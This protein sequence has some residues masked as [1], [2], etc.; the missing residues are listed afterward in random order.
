MYCHLRTDGSP[1]YAEVPWRPESGYRQSWMPVNRR[2][3]GPYE[4]VEMTLRLLTGMGAFATEGCI[5][6]S[7]AGCGSVVEDA[8]YF[9]PHCVELGTV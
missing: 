6:G 5:Q 3:L 8:K 2:C 7:F 9:I 4:I 1:W